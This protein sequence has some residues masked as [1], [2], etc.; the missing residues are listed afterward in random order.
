MQIL[1]CKFTTQFNI[2]ADDQ[3]K[4]QQKNVASQETTYCI[5]DVKHFLI[6]FVIV[7]IPSWL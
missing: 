1:Q 3:L 2:C 6:V 4:V 7:I 5:K